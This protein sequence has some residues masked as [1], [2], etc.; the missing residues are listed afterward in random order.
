MKTLRDNVGIIIL[1]IILVIMAGTIWQRNDDALPSSDCY[2][3]TDGEQVVSEN[4]C[5]Q[6]PYSVDTNNPVIQLIPDGWTIHNIL[7][8]AD[9]YKDEHTGTSRITSE[10][11][12]LTFQMHNGV[13]GV[14][15]Q[16]GYSQNVKLSPGCYL[17]KVSGR[18]WINDPLP[19]HETNFVINGYF[20]E[21]L[22]QQELL[23]RQDGF[24]IIYPFVV[25]ERGTYNLRWM[26]QGLWGSAGDSSKADVLGAGVLAVDSGYCED[27]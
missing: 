10:G 14:D 2:G 25:V 21:G 12:G 1:C 24:Q 15:G 22:L 18:G 8:N 26:V 3:F 20:D 4:H 11:A 9:G 6:P 27:L 5:L 19:G 7:Q 13:N 17:L 16:W 23:Q